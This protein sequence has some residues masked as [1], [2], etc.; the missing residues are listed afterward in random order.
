MIQLAITSKLD[1]H[2][3]LQFLRILLQILVLLC[4]ENNMYIVSNL[5]RCL[6][7]FLISYPVHD[8]LLNHVLILPKQLEICRL[9]MIQLALTSKLETHVL[10][11]F[12]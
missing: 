6:Y 2:V 11:Q 10:L 7:D 4:R 5:F 3:L 9:F 1:I 8:S 12:F